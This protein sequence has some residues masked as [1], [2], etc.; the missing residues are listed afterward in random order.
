MDRGDCVGVIRIKI[1][2]TKQ[3][4][5]SDDKV[6]IACGE[7][8]IKYNGIKLLSM[9]QLKEYTNVII[10]YGRAIALIIMDDLYRKVAVLC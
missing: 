3:V 1:I 2:N 7:N 9:E 4:G 5:L 8:R 10:T 6:Y